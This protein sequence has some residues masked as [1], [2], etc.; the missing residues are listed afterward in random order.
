[1]ASLSFASLPTPP[2]SP[3]SRRSPPSHA[4][5]T[6]LHKPLGWG[7]RSLLLPVICSSSEPN[8]NAD[9][10]PKTA[11]LPPSSST[12]LTYKLY[13]GLGGIGFLETAYLTYLKLTNSAAFCPT[14]PGAGGSCGDILTSDY[15]VVFGNLFNSI[16]N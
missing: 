3:S 13:A 14:G 8:Q 10:D 12:N 7:R 1:M 9:S 2:F 4:G 5:F 6:F 11:S 16:R 15:A